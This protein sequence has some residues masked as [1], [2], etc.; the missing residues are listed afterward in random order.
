MPS[1]LRFYQP[2]RERRKIEFST[3]LN[4]EIVIE[5]CEKCSHY[6]H[7]VILK[8]AVKTDIWEYGIKCRTCG[9]NDIF[10]SH[11]K[12]F[13]EAEKIEGRERDGIKV[14]CISPR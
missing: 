12:Y 13:M 5:K 2:E 11:K 9:H 6:L 7:T 4:E 14:C 3:V 1:E 10:V 8:E